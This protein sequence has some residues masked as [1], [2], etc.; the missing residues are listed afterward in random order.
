[1]KIM[2]SFASMLLISALLVGCGGS[3]SSTE[4]QEATIKELEEKIAEL[5]AELLSYKEDNSNIVAPEEVATENETSDTEEVKEEVKVEPSPLEIVDYYV[6]PDGFIYNDAYVNLKNV[7][8][9]S[10][11]SFEI[12]FL[13]FDDKGFPVNGNHSNTNVEK[14][15]GDRNI[16]PGDTLSDVYWY[17][18]NQ[19]EQIK[20]IVT[21]VN[22]FDR[23][24]WTNP[25]EANW[26]QEEKGRY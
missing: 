2:L 26:I 21:K 18:S 24:P 13:M 9:Y 25:N 16:H 12:T 11:D 15:V 7:S 3:E 1:M 20:V 23:D 14:G 4:N 17:V 6:E 5:E 10:I 19:A 22:F 8:D